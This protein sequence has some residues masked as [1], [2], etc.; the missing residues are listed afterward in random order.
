MDDT[1]NL[2]GFEK[3]YAQGAKEALSKLREAFAHDWEREIC[4]DMVD[5]L[6]TLDEN[7]EWVKDQ[8]EV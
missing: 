4:K 1:F 5:W 7:I 6:D 2:V 3:G 8:L